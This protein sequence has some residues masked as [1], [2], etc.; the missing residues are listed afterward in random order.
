MRRQPLRY[1][2]EGD[3]R[4]GLTHKWHDANILSRYRHVEVSATADCE[5][6]TKR[7][8]SRTLCS[9]MQILQE[10]TMD[11]SILTDV[12]YANE[13]YGLLDN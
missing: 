10:W 2:R 13:S 3:A 9:T 7:M 5:G 8:T 6:K 4:G 12:A 1:A 11:F